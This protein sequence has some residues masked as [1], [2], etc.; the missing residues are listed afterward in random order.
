[1]SET[2]A[3]FEMPQYGIERA[4]GVIGRALQTDFSMRF[5]ACA[6]TEFRR[7]GICRD[8]ARRTA[9]K[10][11]PL[12]RPP[13]PSGPAAAQ[14]R[15]RGRPRRRM[16]GR[17]W[18]GNGWHH[19]V[20]RSP[21]RPERRAE[22]LQRHQ[23]NRLE[24]K[25]IPYECTGTGGNDDAVARG[26]GLQPRREVRGLAEHGQFCRGADRDRFANDD[27]AAG[28]ADT[29]IEFG[30]IDGVARTA[31]RQRCRAR[32][33]WPVRRRPRAPADN[34]NRPARRRP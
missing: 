27:N 1:M 30:P 22:A 13:A 16:S 4:V 29:A 10:V 9:E 6:R 34:R 21:A 3:A 11:D 15:H 5:D 31:S 32:L 25:P 8:R 7:G 20:Q 12:R 18:R 2:G 19:C 14:V 26:D 23:F 28:N 24:L 33:G 17:G